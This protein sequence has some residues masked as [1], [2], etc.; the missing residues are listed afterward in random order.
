M[1]FLGLMLFSLGSVLTSFVH[2]WVG[3]TTYIINIFDQYYDWSIRLW[4]VYLVIC[5][6]V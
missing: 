3:G 2:G 4:L 6:G 5:V 1:E